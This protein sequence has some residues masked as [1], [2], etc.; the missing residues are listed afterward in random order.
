M[1][2]SLESMITVAKAAEILG[3]TPRRIQQLLKDEV[4][5]G[6]RLTERFWLVDIKSVEKYGKNPQSTGRPRISAAT[7][8]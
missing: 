1:S 8:K 3:C 5:K 2:T 6:R 7:Q 4:L